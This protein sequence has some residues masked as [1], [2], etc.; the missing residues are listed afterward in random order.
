[1]NTL[2]TLLISIGITA[3]LVLFWCL[4]K[5]YNETTDTTKKTYAILLLG[6]S[7]NFILLFYAS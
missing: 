5:I 6:N 2:M 4:F 1:M 7:Y 3:S